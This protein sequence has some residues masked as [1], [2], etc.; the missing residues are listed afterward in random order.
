MSK[1]ALQMYTLREYTQTFED[2]EKT[3]KKLKSIGYE[4][5]QYSVPENADL[6]ELKNLIESLG[7]HIISSA[8]KAEEIKNKISRIEALTAAFGF[9]HIGLHSMPY[10]A[11]TSAEALKHYCD[12]VN[13]AGILV[14]KLGLKLL[15]HSH[16]FE[17]YKI[18]G[19]RVIDI[20]EK[21]T[22]PEILTLM[23]D[24]H[25]LQ[26]GGID[27]A[28]YILEHAERIDFL[29]FKDYAI[30]KPQDGEK[31]ENV[32]KIFAPVGRGNLNWKKI[33]AAAKKAN[34]IYNIVEQDESYGENVFECVKES[35]EFMKRMGADE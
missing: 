6:T 30:A 16:A 8:F 32:K 26:S 29:H 22:D 20:L 34:T 28:E 18:D 31:I 33:I 23:P 3:L 9:R 1:I 27:P 25:W 12:K 14:K 5:I 35:Y 2:L 19:E 7:M 17:F 13:D 4:N 24:T 15:Y 10:S 11:L 21:N